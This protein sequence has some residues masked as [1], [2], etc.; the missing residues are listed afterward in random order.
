MEGMIPRIVCVTWWRRKAGWWRRGN[1]GIVKPR[2]NT[3]GHGFNRRKQRGTE[4]SKIIDGKIIR[5]KGL[6]RRTEPV[7]P[8][9]KQ[10]RGDL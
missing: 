7:G 10:R 9:R 8:P 4:R 6:N 5:G 2:I 3:D 1:S